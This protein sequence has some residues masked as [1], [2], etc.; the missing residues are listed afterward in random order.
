MF[1]VGACLNAVGLNGTAGKLELE[2]QMCA[3]SEEVDGFRGRT[4]A[5]D[6]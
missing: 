2:E 5:K 3:I 4:G 6:P 1:T